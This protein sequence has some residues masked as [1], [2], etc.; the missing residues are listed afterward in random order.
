[1]IDGEPCANISPRNMDCLSDGNKGATNTSKVVSEVASAARADDMKKILFIAYYFP[2]MGGSGVQRAHKFARY[3]PEEAYL[4]V[5]ITG[6][7]N[8]KDPWAQKAPTLSEGIHSEVI[9]HHV[10]TTLLTLIAGCGKTDQMGCIAKPIF[11]MVG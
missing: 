5:V 9:V 3:L 2:P 6:P 1:M 11:T 8:R 10:K 7:P 4:P